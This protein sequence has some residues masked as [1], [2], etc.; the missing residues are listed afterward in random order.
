MKRLRRET[1]ANPTKAAI[2]GGLLLVA[3]YFWAPLVWSWIGPSPEE[4]KSPT[5][6]AEDVPTPLAGFPSALASAK[7]QDTTQGK[8]QKKASEYPWSRVTQWIEQDAAMRPV[9]EP[10]TARDPFVAVVAKL[11]EAPQSEVPKPAEA[12]VEVTPD[13]L[14]LVLSSTLVG[15]R[16]RTALINGRSYQQGRVVALEQGGRQLEFKLAEVHPRRAVLTRDN[17][18]YELTVP[19]LAPAGRLE[20]YGNAN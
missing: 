16:R 18:R 8:K 19:K 11:V 4:A 9:V 20:I 1:A 3:M 12:A 17:K 6:A 13:S 7:H 5:V 15:P 14:G 10:S 2:L